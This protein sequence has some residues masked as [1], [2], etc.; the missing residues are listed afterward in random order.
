MNPTTRLL[1]PLQ[2]F[3]MMLSTTL[4]PISLTTRPVPS[5][6][7]SLPASTSAIIY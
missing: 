4:R 5:R 3:R 2:D 6:F 7:L 1:D